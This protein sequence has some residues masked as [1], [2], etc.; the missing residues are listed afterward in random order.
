MAKNKNMFGLK[1]IESRWR[2]PVLSRGVIKN[3]ASSTRSTGVRSAGPKVL[4]L[5]YFQPLPFVIHYNSRVRADC[6]YLSPFSRWWPPQRWWQAVGGP[7]NPQSVHETQFF[8]GKL[9]LFQSCRYIHLY[10]CLLSSAPCGPDG[11][12]LNILALAFFFFFFKSSVS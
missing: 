3:S 11:S 4:I 5:T 9:P 1:H 12:N 8:W 7:A 6:C 10:I 2:A